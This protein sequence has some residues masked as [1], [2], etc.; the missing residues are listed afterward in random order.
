MI[1][2]L[3]LLVTILISMGSIPQIIK[4][5]KTK[6]AESFSWSFVITMLIC[7]FSYGIL[8]LIIGNTLTFILELLLSLSWLVILIVKILNKKESDSE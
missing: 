7:T 4:A 5:I 8:F 3:F 6:D 2:V 1:D